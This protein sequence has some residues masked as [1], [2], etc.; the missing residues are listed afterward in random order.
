M[1]IFLHFS[2]SLLSSYWMIDIMSDLELFN[3][4]LIKY[5]NRTK[6]ISKVWKMR[7]PLVVMFGVSI[8]YIDLEE[9]NMYDLY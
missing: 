1:E 6:R 4:E 3:F 5:E 8:F 2:V 7:C 9:M